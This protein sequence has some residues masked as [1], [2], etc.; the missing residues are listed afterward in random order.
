MSDIKGGINLN[1]LDCFESSLC[2]IIYLY[3]LPYNLLF[4]DLLSFHFDLKHQQPIQIGDINLKRSCMDLFGLYL[5]SVKFFK[6]IGDIK[7]IRSLLKQNESNYVMI[8]LNLQVCHWVKEHLRKDIVHV[9]IVLE[10]DMDIF[11]CIDPMFDAQPIYVDV[12]F[13]I[14]N[15]EGH[16]ITHFDLTNSRS[17]PYKLAREK[18]ADYLSALDSSKDYMALKDSFGDFMDLVLNKKSLY[19]IS[20]E[21]ML[22]FRIPGL[23]VLFKTF[24][25]SIM[26]DS[27][28][29]ERIR[30]LTGELT[31]KWQ[32]IKVLMQKVLYK[33]SYTPAVKESL[34]DLFGDV[35]VLEEK[36]RGCLL[37]DMR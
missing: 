31:D 14:K 15:Y 28:S 10:S 34:L 26:P 19:L 2:N 36:V 23:R 8:L 27:V 22:T 25:D 6:N 1:G 33:G 11:C 21:Y 12:E 35:S 3:S 16:V 37:D 17:C 20:L 29:H 7:L 18:T 5:S 13:L 32:G 4:F 30:R 24:V 9:I